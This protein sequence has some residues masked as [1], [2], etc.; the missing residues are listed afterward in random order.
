MVAVEGIALPTGR[1]IDGKYLDQNEKD[2]EGSV[3]KVIW[4]HI[5]V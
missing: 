1:D 4:S 5:D 3:R 2:L